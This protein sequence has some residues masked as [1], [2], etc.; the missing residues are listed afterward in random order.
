MGHQLP[1]LPGPHLA[2]ACTKSPNFSHERL[3]TGAGIIQAKDPGDWV[4]SGDPG[5]KPGGRGPGSAHASQADSPQTGGQGGGPQWAVFT[6]ESQSP[7]AGGPPQHDPPVNRD[8]G[9]PSGLV[10]PLPTLQ[11]P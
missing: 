7:R 8:P 4:S 3:T 6:P 9:L 1:S 11:P 10:A 2:Q 5:A